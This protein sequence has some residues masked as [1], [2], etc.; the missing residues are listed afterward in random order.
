M[1]IVLRFLFYYLE[2]F[3][4]ISSLSSLVSEYEWW[5]EE[6]LVN[7]STLCRHGSPTLRERHLSLSDNNC[8][9]LRELLFSPLCIS[10][11]LSNDS[12]GKHSE[13]TEGASHCHSAPFKSIASNDMSLVTLSAKA[14]S[15]LKCTLAFE[16]DKLGWQCKQKCSFFKV[17]TLYKVDFVVFYKAKLT[18]STWFQSAC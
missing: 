6:T 17:F 11:Q 1:N 13:A 9:G 16:T 10:G 15:D 14:F 3:Y 5:G 7:Q 8:C 18:V 12:R 4:H 2:H